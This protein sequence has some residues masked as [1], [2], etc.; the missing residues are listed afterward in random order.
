MSDPRSPNYNER[1]P[2][3]PLQYIVLHYTG[4]QTAHEALSRL[5]DPLSKV[6]AHYF[7]YED[8]NILQLV[9]DH[10]RAWH[11]G[12]S[13]WHGMT[14]L[15]SASLGIELVNPGHHFGYRAYPAPQIN[16]LKKKLHQLISQHHL[17]PITSLLSHSEIAPDRKEDPGELFPWHE[18]AQEG[19]GPWPHPEADDYRPASDSDIQDM[20]RT[21][22]YTCP[23]THAYDRSTRALL[24]AF[25]RRYEPDNITGTP[26]RETI[27][28]LRALIRVF[29]TE[30]SLL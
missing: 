3:V 14:D 29:K 11:A 2:S 9:D 25:Q 30:Q 22:G 6:S 5:C 12:K 19:L 4:M 23:N 28:R 24:L 17:D 16:A 18:L 20:L 27:A 15:N 1:D 21:L 13:F 26:E 10:K 8:G 7:I